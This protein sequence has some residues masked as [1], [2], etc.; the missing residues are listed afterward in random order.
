MRHITEQVDILSH[1]L[2]VSEQ[3][4]AF[5]D[6]AAIDK[7]IAAIESKTVPCEPYAAAARSQLRMMGHP[8][9]CIAPEETP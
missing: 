1:T 3:D 6:N 5:A 9:L 4:G 8:E 2:G 7:M